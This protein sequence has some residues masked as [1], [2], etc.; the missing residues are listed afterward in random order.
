MGLLPPC[1]CCA[2]PPGA[3]P[4]GGAPAGAKRR[5]AW[6]QRLF[7]TLTSWTD[8]GN[9]RLLGD[10]KRALLSGLSGDVVELGPGTGAN[11]HHFGPGVHWTGVEPN[12]YMHPHLRQRAEQLGLRLDLRVGT[13]EHTG[14]P[15]GSAD[16]VVATLVLCS[17]EDVPGALAEVRRLLRPGGRFVFLEHVAAP[18]GTTLRRTQ[19]LVQPLWS[20]IADGC[21][22]DRET[23][24]DL[25][26]AGFAALR[27]DRFRIET[28]AP[29]AFTSPAIA[30]TAST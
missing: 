14:L 23:W 29:M 6:A 8:A 26:G 12:P 18:E 13:A 25:E 1:P 30:G 2:T 9:E 7:A 27:Y 24:A 22:P 11:L 19:R 16:A 4:A 20:I 17:V 3:P 21:H 15:D 10:R 5:P 28:P